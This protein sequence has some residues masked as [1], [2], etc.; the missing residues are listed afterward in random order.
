MTRMG[1]LKEVIRGIK[2][3]LKRLLKQSSSLKY[4]YHCFISTPKLP[5]PHL[6]CLQF[7]FKIALS[8]YFTSTCLRISENRNL[9]AGV[10]MRPLFFSFCAHKKQF[11]LQNVFT[12][13]QPPRESN[14]AYIHMLFSKI[15]M[16]KMKK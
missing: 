1:G 7:N 13:P 5:I 11:L 6:F 4:R 8:L 10:P 3:G 15:I 16:P 9:T 2:E 12:S 14:R